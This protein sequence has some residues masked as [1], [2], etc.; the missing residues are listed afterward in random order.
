MESPGNERA[1]STEKDG[2]TESVANVFSITVKIDVIV[3]K[4]R[5][6]LNI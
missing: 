5:I 6:S 3:G 2:Q 1:V 4:G